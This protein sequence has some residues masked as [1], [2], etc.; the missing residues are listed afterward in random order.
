LNDFQEDRRTAVQRFGEGLHQIS[1]FVSINENAQ[2]PNR[3]PVHID[4][5]DAT[6]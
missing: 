4:L 6:L 3:F 5:A 2:L 1:P